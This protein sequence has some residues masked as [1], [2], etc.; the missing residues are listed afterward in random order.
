M[1]PA[2][3]N[4]KPC[5]FCGLTPNPSPEDEDFDDIPECLICVTCQCFDSGMSDTYVEKPTWNT[6][7]IED[8]Q[9]A[10]I[11][12]LEAKLE[13]AIAAH[14]DADP[15][16]YLHCACVAPLT[17]RVAELEAELAALRQDHDLAVWDIN[18]MAANMDAAQAELAA[19]RWIRVTARDD[20][21]P[22]IDMT[23]VE[24][25][26]VTKVDGEFLAMTSGEQLKRLA[27]SGNPKIK[28]YYWRPFTPPAEA[29]EHP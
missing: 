12:E 1:K 22:P 5:P 18:R 27:A 26:L 15:A 17:A 3:T 13:K 19:L 14:D 10:L 9:T 23:Q 8:A 6:R 2:M 25:L 24:M 4:I 20:S 21:L 29:G 7:P 28:D 16:N 11:V